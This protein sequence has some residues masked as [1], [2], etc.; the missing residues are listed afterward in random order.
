MNSIALLSSGLDSTV[1]L[2]KAQETSRVVLAITFDY[3]QRAA[4][5]E[6]E[7]ASKAC[8]ALKIEHKVIDLSFFKDFTNTSLI[9]VSKEIP[10]NMHIDDLA[11]CNDTAKAVWVPNRNGIMINIAAG[12]AEGLNAEEVIVGFNKEEGATF[13]DNTQS[14]IDKVNESLELSTLKKVRV[15][16]YTT[17]LNKSEIVDLGM[18]CGVNFEYVWPCYFGGARPC[19]QCE[20]CLRYLRAVKNKKIK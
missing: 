2:Y 13:P 4:T 16:C 20:S 7:N 11:E 17:Q 1:N 14:Y 6:I 5:K 12:F 3:G 10:L 19:G 15:N 9:S 18:K 8:Y